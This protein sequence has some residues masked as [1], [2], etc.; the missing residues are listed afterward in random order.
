MT[1]QEWIQLQLKNVDARR[2]TVGSIAARI[3][4]VLRRLR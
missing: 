4:R 3:A 2:H 1:D